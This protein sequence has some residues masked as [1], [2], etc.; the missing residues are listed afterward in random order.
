[1]RFGRNVEM[2]DNDLALMA[3]TSDSSVLLNDP[4][5]HNPTSRKP[6]K[7]ALSFEYFL[8]FCFITQFF[9]PSSKW[10][11]KSSIK[12]LKR[13]CLVS[14]VPLFWINCF[15]FFCVLN[16]DSWKSKINIFASKI[17]NATNSW[18]CCETVYA[19]CRKPIRPTRKTIEPVP[20][21]ESITSTTF[22]SFFGVT[23]CSLGFCRCF[24][25]CLV[26][27]LHSG[28]CSLF[29]LD[30]CVRVLWLF[31]LL[32]LLWSLTSTSLVVSHQRIE[33]EREKARKRERSKKE[34]E[35][36]SCSCRQQS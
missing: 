1:M 11:R 2:A 14:N 31:A 9:F 27:F 34:K 19:N 26:F 17:K 28:V 7:P 33:K 13:R 4:L 24:L 36:K 16:F 30:V 23:F 32:C 5:V 21:Y 12:S 10:M 20:R 18:N 15:P 29:H 3:H 8:P 25:S 6:K 35:R 22:F